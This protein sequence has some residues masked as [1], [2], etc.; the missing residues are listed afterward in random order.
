VN[1]V[2]IHCSQYF[3]KAQHE[4]AEASIYRHIEAVEH[5]YT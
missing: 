3:W 5:K 4:W 1:F 2:V